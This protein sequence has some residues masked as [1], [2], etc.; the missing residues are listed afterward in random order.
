MP[1]MPDHPRPQGLDL[2]Q[3]YD[4]ETLS[5]IEAQ[6]VPDGSAPLVAG[7]VGTPEQAPGATHDDVT[8]EQPADDAADARAA[9]PVRF[10]GVRGAVLAGA[11]LGVAE[12]FEPE[13]D[14][15]SVV[16][17]APAPADHK[18]DPIEF[19]FV[20]G[21]PERSRIIYRPWL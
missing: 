4:D 12:V 15:Q 18:D 8:Q 2:E 11:M 5:L 3:L 9:G 10:R 20:R 6:T 13:P 1:V 17:F 19:I 7:R 16:E 21:A 14:K